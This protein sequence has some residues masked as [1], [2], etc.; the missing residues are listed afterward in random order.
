MKTIIKIFVTSCLVLGVLCS[1]VSAREIGEINQFKIT[2]SY[3]TTDYLLK[4]NY[5][6]DYVINLIPSREHEPIKIL[7]RLVNS[8]GDRRSDNNRS[9]CGQRYEYS[10][11]GENGYIYA[12]EMSREHIFDWTIYITGSWSPD[13]Y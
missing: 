10:S 12:L 9:V 7:N 5:H 8:N 6:G 1:A 11:W 13:T 4:E 3:R 2:T